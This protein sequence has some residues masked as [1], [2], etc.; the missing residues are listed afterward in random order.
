VRRPRRRTH[1][2]RAD[3]IG[4]AVEIA[5]ASVVVIATTDAA[6]TGSPLVDALYRAG[7]VAAT[8]MAGARARRWNLLIA[9]ALVAVG[10][11]G[12]MLVPAAAALVL[13]FVM[14]W[15]D[16]RHRLL[17][18]AAGALVA[19]AALDLAW[20]ASPTG[21]TAALAAA[22][23]VPLWISGWR[24]AR[25]PA[26]RAILWSLLGAAALALVAVA[27]AGVFAVT[28]RATLVDAAD[29]TVQAASSITSSDG[30][31]DLSVFERNEQD[32]RSVAAASSAWWMLPTRAVPVVA[33]HVEA[34]RVAATSGAELNSFAA[35]LAGSV[36]YDRLQRPDGSID[37]AL[38]AQFGQPVSDADRTLRT[39]SADL[40]A[41]ESPWLVPPL[42]EQLQSFRAEVDDAAGAT[43]VA[44]AA[45]RHLPGLLGAGG[46]RR[47][48]LLLGNPAE[49]RD[50]GGHLG[51]WAELVVTDGKIDV[52][53]VGV[54][55]DLFAPGTDPAPQ[56]SSEEGLPP[57]LLE[58]Q[59]TRFPQNWGAS[60][61][62]ATVSRLAAQL[63]PQAAGGAPI[64]GV[65]YADPVA[66]A[67]LL[68]L[69]GPVEA[70][71]VRLDADNAVQYLTRDQ[72]LTADPRD[73]PVSDL[74]R[75]G[76][77][78]L[79]DN[80]LPGTQQISS[81]FSEVVASGHLQ[82]FSLTTAENELMELVGLDQPVPV[83]DRS[84]VVAVLSRNA[85]PS[86]IDAFLS[87]T[88]DYDV[89]WEPSTGQV[90]S[91]VVVT[92]RN[93]APA[94]GLPALVIGAA[95]ALPPGTNR[96]QL[97][98]VSPFDAVGTMVDGQ[99]VG[100][101]SREDL[102]G[103]RRHS[104]LVDLPPG[105]E[106]TVVV[107]LE[108]SVEPGPTYRLQWLNQPLLQDDSSQLLIEAVGATFPG[109]ASEGRV[110]IGDRRV[111][112]ISVSTE[113]RP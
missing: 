17:G 11:D 101:S 13:G 67:A 107:D 66:F 102:D 89:Q 1:S 20:P 39:V 4:L 18:G 87:R 47:Y 73:A 19:W 94:A 56:L 42:A 31:A 23:L 22:A 35:E 46:P 91:R 26:Q 72:F 41:T 51:N 112:S 32:F 76:L 82:F 10:S 12:W 29:A 98:V 28:Q 7:V 113:E 27:L 68:R 80:Q 65:L 40:A 77:E 9:A 30:A 3:R 5:V 97:S 100:S 83:P 74:V 52:V 92:L 50:L 44:D 110:P 104:V 70:G 109:G 105:A 71:G 34:V 14:A 78:R 93:D 48:L 55:Y 69:T 43:T 85:N 84:D 95:V 2:T 96:T 16:R 61:D 75:A 79:T 36:D 25:R 38:L 88:I 62:L 106:R 63:Y 6:P 45:V 24:N 108:G 81:A 60:P 64:D 111:E 99:P 86:K 90:R 8:V 103:L 53:R 49:A 15:R 33:Q 21:A 37:L 59:P 54:P 57:S 58:M